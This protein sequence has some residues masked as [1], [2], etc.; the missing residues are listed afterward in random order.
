[1]N[2]YEYLRG[3]HLTPVA[4]FS[5]ERQ[6]LTEHV[7][8]RECQLLTEDRITY[9]LGLLSGRLPPYGTCRWPPLPRPC[10]ICR[11]PPAPY[12]TCRRPPALLWHLQ[13]TACPPMASAGGCPPPCGTCRRP[14]ATLWHLQAAIRPLMAPTGGRPP[15]HGTC[16]R[17]PAA[18]WHHQAAARRMLINV[19]IFC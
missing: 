13:A 2:K 6:L 9:H 4:A 5:M 3:Q 12:V 19:P 8:Y 14:P 17:P 15:P 11:L 7:Q 10:G 16:R 18:L 1:M